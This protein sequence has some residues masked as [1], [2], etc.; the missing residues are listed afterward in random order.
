M[1]FKCQNSILSCLF[2][3]RGWPAILY[4]LWLMNVLRFIRRQRIISGPLPDSGTRSIAG[5]PFLESNIVHDSLS[6][7]KW[8][9]FM[10]PFNYSILEDKWLAWE[11]EVKAIQRKLLRLIVNLN[12]WLFMSFYLFL[13]RCLL[14]ISGGNLTHL[15]KPQKLCT[16]FL[17]NATS[18]K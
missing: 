8:L 2:V 5:W 18:S 12:T 3:S 13:K 9:N 16:D 17:F 10:C 14:Q 7:V 1:W 11:C 6:Y 15:K 4:F